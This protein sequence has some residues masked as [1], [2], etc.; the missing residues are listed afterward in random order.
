MSCLGVHFALSEEEV[1]K[2]TSFGNDEE[3]LDY[4][5]EEIEEVYLE[6]RESLIAQSDKAWDAIHRAFTDGQLAYDNGTYPLNHVILGG[7]PLYFNDDYILSL[8][9]PDQ[10]KAVAE[11]LSAISEKEFRDLYF[12]I[13]PDLYD[14]D[15][16]EEDFEYSW[17]WLKEIVALFNTAAV[18][19]RYVL[20]TADQ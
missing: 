4:V 20:F 1:K 15:I 10:V 17:S 11:A 2:L 13:N 6:E 9:T 7:A 5:T 12:N 16:S 3:R 18:N 14:G 19:G 8:K